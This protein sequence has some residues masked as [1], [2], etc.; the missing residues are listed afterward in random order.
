MSKNAIFDDLC[1]PVPQKLNDTRCYNFVTI[2]FSAEPTSSLTL[3]K[4]C[5]GE[6][7]DC[8]DLAWNDLLAMMVCIEGWPYKDG[9]TGL[10]TSVTTQGWQYRAGHVCPSVFMIQLEN[11]LALE[12]DAFTAGHIGLSMSV[13]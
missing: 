7:M 6:A 1:T 12:L 5:E 9:H 10:T 11:C 4:I 13:W 8:D 3:I 2:L